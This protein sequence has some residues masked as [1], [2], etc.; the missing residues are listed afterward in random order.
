MQDQSRAQAGVRA[1]L[2]RAWPLLVI[3]ACVVQCLA[4]GWGRWGDILVDTGRELEWPRRILEREWLYADLRYNYGPLGPYLN[5]ALYA[6]FGVR[7]EVLAAAGVATAVLTAWVVYAIA[8][9]FVGRLGATAAAVYFLYACAFGHLEPAAVFNFVLP[10]A[11]AATYGMLTALASLLYLVRYARTDRP[12]HQWLAL[13]LLCLAALAKIEVLFPAVVAHAIFFAARVHAGRGSRLVRAYALAAAGAAGVYLLFL[14]RAGAPLWGDNLAAVVNP[15]SDYFIRMQMGL[16]EPWLNVARMAVA[17]AVLAVAA[18]A[19]LAAGLVAGMRWR[20]QPVAAVCAVLGCALA[21]GMLFQRFRH[22]APLP[23]RAMPA[24]VLAGLLGSAAAWWARPR[25]RERWLPLL[26]TFAFAMASLPRVLLNSTNDLYGYF[27]LPPSLVCLC[28][29]LFEG[30]PRALRGAPAPG[31]AIAAGAAAFI[32]LHSATLASLSQERFDAKTVRLSTSRGTLLLS[33]DDAEIYVPVV[34][35]LRRA[36]RSAT[37]LTLP[38]ATCLQF[39]TEHPTPDG[40]P[41]HVPMDFFGGFSDQRMRALWEKMPPDLVF[42][43]DVEMDYFGGAR[44]CATYGQA[45]CAFLLDRYVPI[46]GPVG[47]RFGPAVLLVRR[48]LQWP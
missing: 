3:T 19:L 18:I 39:L 42:W 34:S 2:S 21:F 43:V 35:A 8:R 29:L 46:F 16:T 20:P 40:N 37:L 17:V 1:W 10:H 12:L 5:A 14:L 44:Y 36:P 9:E 41:T 25:E 24:L 30:L 11:F 32:G 27:L 47:T 28:I 15:A 4:V 6:L 38:H 31:R 48:G 23:F 22:L 45:S 7:L 13:L 33:P 26:L